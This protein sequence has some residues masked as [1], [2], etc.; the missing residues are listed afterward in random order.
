MASQLLTKSKKENQDLL[1]AS[2]IQ[3]LLVQRENWNSS[4]FEPSI[5]VSSIFHNTE[6]NFSGESFNAYSDPS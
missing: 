6:G 2:K 4:F 1:R 3:E 5:A